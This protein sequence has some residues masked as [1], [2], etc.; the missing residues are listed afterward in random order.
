MWEHLSAVLKILMRSRKAF[1]GHLCLQMETHKTRKG[2]RK[3][4]IKVL[5]VQ[6]CFAQV[7]KKFCPTPI[8]PKSS[9][10]I[11][12]PIFS[13]ITSIYRQVSKHY[14]ELTD[15]PSLF[16]LNLLQDRFKAAHVHVFLKDFTF[17]YAT[18]RLANT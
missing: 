14:P 2:S 9:I 18:H 17:N 5:A 12:R 11:T 8:N 13:I 1:L 6:A 15:S 7:R 10:G 16:A 4:G 3:S